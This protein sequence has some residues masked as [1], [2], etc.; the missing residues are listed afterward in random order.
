M[1]LATT[2][3]I[4]IGVGCAAACVLVLIAPAAALAWVVVE[5]CI[6]DATGYDQAV[7]SIQ[8]FVELTE[9][10]R[11]EARDVPRL[12]LFDAEGAA[13]ASPAIGRALDLKDSARRALWAAPVEP[14]RRARIVGRV[15]AG[16]NAT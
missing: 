10:S 2:S 3:D 11:A 8:R 6:G 4:W 1:V 5:R 16:L 9:R 14:R 13:A 12:P 7:D 15:A